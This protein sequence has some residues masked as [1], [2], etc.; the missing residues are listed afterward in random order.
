MVT[1]TVNTIVILE[2]FEIKIH[3]VT[4]INDSRIHI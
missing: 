1:L 4:Y 3:N 2:Q